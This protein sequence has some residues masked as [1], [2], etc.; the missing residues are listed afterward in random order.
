MGRVLAC[1]GE[2]ALYP[3]PGERR[4]GAGYQHAAL[5]L[6]HQPVTPTWFP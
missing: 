4:Y 1:G 3:H 6:C 2:G 5:G